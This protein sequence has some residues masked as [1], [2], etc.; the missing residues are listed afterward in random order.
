MF[1]PMREWYLVHP[2][3]IVVRRDGGAA[4][5]PTADD[6]AGL[7]IDE[8]S[9]LEAG[10]G[11]LRASAAPVGVEVALPAPL[12]VISLREA[13]EVLGEAQFLAAGRATQLVEWAT[14]SRF[15][16]RCGVGTEHVAGE[17]AT[18]CPRCA[19]V[20]YPR[21]APAIIVLVRQG[22][23]ALL[24]RN[25]RSK[26]PFYSTLAGFAEI[27]ES[28]EQTVVREV[29]EE[30]GIEVDRVRYFGSQPWP[31]PHSLMVGFNAEWKSG[32]LQVDGVEIAEARWFRADALP[33]IPPRISIARR[34]IDAWT[35][36][37]LAGGSS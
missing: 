14:T 25:A 32:D 3:G 28:L 10:E 7:S 33:L 11:E 8:A 16:G 21:I 24:A 27:G 17:R 12:E 5:L 4:S 26:M 18:R 36:E 31:F 30:V 37:V 35:A 29:R 6:V 19:L 1:P 20:A 2:R 22:D 34:L 9:I 23:Q 13:F 15:C